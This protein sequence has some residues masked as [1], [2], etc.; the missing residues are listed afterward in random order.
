MNFPDNR[1]T[2]LRAAYCIYP[3]DAQKCQKKKAFVLKN[4]IFLLKIAGRKK[5]A[6]GTVKQARSIVKSTVTANLSNP[7]VM[8]DLN[9]LIQV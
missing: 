2:F 9:S 6:P 8:Q 1:Q 3:S 7:I 5:M 4:A